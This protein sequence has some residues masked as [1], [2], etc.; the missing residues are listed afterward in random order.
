MRRVLHAPL[1]AV[2]PVDV[3]VPVLGVVPVLVVVRV[4]LTRATRGALLLAA[5][6]RSGLH[7]GNG[8]QRHQ[9]RERGPG[10]V[11]RVQNGA[12]GCCVA[13]GQYARHVARVS[14]VLV[15]H[16]LHP[17]SREQPEGDR[18]WL[19]PAAHHLVRLDTDLC[20]PSPAP[21]HC[22]QLPLDHQR[23]RWSL[24]PSGDRCCRPRAWRR[25]QPC[26]CR[27]ARA[28]WPPWDADPRGRRAR[29]TVHHGTGAC[30][31]SC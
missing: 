15:P 23:W 12:H 22:P 24:L 27:R 3:V 26:C 1:L 11:V 9:G 8:V 10:L 31:D 20:P 7:L 17:R 19:D 30:C 13:L 28:G 21:V 16:P 14:R 25:W 6:A 29:W 2:V 5:T 4:L 18:L